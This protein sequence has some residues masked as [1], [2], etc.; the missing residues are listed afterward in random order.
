MVVR[1]LGGSAESVV[2]HVPDDEDAAAHKRRRP[3]AEFS[4]H[5]M[6]KE[7]G[8]GGRGETHAAIL[9]AP[10][11]DGERQQRRRQKQPQ[12]RGM[13]GLVVEQLGS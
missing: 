10:A 3:L 1:A 6:A 2:A 9:V 5:V 11:A 7:R 12:N 4:E 13:K 8:E